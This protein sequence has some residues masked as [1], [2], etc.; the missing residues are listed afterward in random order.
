MCGPRL[1]ACVCVLGSVFASF[2]VPAAGGQRSDAD[3]VARVGAYVE[4]YYT[5][6]LTLVVTETV[7]VEP[8]TRRLEPDG[9]ARQIV[10]EMRI[11]W[12]GTIGSEPREV[13]RLIT[14]T[15][16]RFTPTGQPDCPD[17]RPVAFAPLAMLL[18][19]N[20]AGFRFSTGRFEMIN[21]VGT[22]RIDYEIRR[23][24]PPR[25][26]WN[27]KCGW[28]DSYG[29]TRGTV[30]VNPSSG[31]V[32]RLSE[33]LSGRVK[34]PGP[35]GD[36]YAPEFVA[37]RADS[38]IDY[39]PFAFTDPEETLLLPSRVESVTFIQNS[40]APRVRITSTFTNY[41]RFLTDGRIVP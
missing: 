6:A 27:G 15:G 21:G 33:R 41:R 26:R 1:I 11:E 34:L 38:T 19:A 23:A 29:R 16:R 17:Q 28:V 36:K 35:P 4:Q 8:I 32:I 40:G 9:P 3:L 24:Q 30:W 22:Q 20:R 7:S 12:D 5:R 14:S 18:P 13:R 39:R 37:E 10:N 2:V 31:E 25:V